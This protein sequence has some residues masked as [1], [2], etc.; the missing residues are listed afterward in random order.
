MKSIKKLQKKMQQ[1]PGKAMWTLAREMGIGM[2]TM[3]KALN[4]D[5]CYSS[6]KRHKGQLL[7]AKGQENCLTKAKK[8][9]NKVKH[10]FELGVLWFFSGPV[11]QY[12]EQQVAS[13]QSARSPALHE[14]QV[15]SNC[16]GLCMCFQ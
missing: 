6:Y 2:M 8:L 9:L 3:K 14:D 16:E 13:L 15:P 4:K 1:D 12:I 7:T 10:S 11:A 5:L